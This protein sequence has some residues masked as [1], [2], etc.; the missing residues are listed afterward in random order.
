[1]GSRRAIVWL[2]LALL[3]MMPGAVLAS[4]S[5]ASGDTHGQPSGLQHSYRTGTAWRNFSTALVAEAPRLVLLGAHQA[6]VAEVSVPPLVLRSP[7]F[8]PPRP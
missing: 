1:M 8:V 6:P 2:L 3:V 7:I 5:L 4:R